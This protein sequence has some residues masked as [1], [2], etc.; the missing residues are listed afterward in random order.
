[1]KM[2]H[3]RL[4]GLIY[5]QPHAVLPS[6]MDMAETWAANTLQLNLVNVAAGS[7]ELWEP[8]AARG[9]AERMAAA[10]ATGVQTVPVHGVLMPRSIHMD[11]C[12]TAT[13]Y[14][15]LRQQISAAVNDPQIDHVVLDID[16][17]GGS[18]A[19]C[20]ELAQDIRTWSQ[21]KPITA[22]VNYGAYSAAY[23]LASAA[24]QIV[25]APSSGV[26]SIGVIARHADISGRN[27]QQGVKVTSIYAGA[28]KNDLSPHEPLSDDASA[29]LQQHV[30]SSYQTF[31]NTV[32]AH[33]GLS[34][35]AVRGTEADVFHGADAVAQGLADRVETPQAA[36]NRIAAEVADARRQRTTTTIAPRRASIAMRAR[37][38]DIATSM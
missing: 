4:L 19:G 22:V 3:L 37:A 35:E 38:A 1:M 27:A 8:S 7:D 12:T 13:N 28:R 34:P 5:N 10:H 16:S 23:A 29:R 15:A 36:M 25:V 11:P 20:F 26:G 31:V 24:S 2:P 21:Q 18:V 9:D 6:M 32:S 14:E 30:D 33:R 17:P